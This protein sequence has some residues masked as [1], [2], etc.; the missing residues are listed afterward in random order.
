MKRFKGYAIRYESFSEDIGF[1]AVIK[2][3][4]LKDV[5]SRSDVLCLCNHD[6]SQGLLGR[7]TK[8][9]GSMT[10]TSDSQGLMFQVTPPSAAAPL[11]ESVERRD[12]TGCSFAFTLAK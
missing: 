3:T 12:M 2:A 10:L 8:G 7:C 6:L 4:A 11:I 1:K 5:I 9:Q